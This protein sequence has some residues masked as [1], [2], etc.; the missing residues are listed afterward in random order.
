MKD[1]NKTK[2]QLIKELRE[3]RKQFDD[4]K[5]LKNENKQLKE[6]LH[7]FEKAIETVPVGVTITNTL[8]EIIYTNS[9]E[10]KMHGYKI[11]DL[12]GKDVRIL[13]PIE[14]RNPASIDKMKKWTGFSRESINIRKDDS[15]FPVWLMSNII[16][17]TTDYP[18]AII[19][20]SEDITER[21]WN[22]K[23]LQER[24]ARF[25]RMADNI[26]D[27]LIIIE[28]GKVIYINNRTCEILGYP[29]EELINLRF[30]DIAAH[31]EKKRLQKIMENAKKTN[32]FPEKLEF[33]TLQKDGNKRYIHTRY[34]LNCIDDKI[35]GRF[36]IITDITKQKLAEE[37]LK[38]SELL[39]HTIVDSLDYAI[40]VIDSN[41]QITLFNKTFAKWCKNLGME[42]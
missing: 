9:A 12:I 5:K 26:Q 34:S 7:R 42:T 4:F 36:I 25:R 23:T 39:Y 27:G 21:K 41:M 29:K 28:K 17:D 40:H 10:A 31:E 19:T 13:A 24:E 3:L 20:I 37:A 6:E 8:G 30:L 15:T 18:I 1:E 38:K 33:W 11:E 32:H 2:K 14:L 22:E 16:K 35:I